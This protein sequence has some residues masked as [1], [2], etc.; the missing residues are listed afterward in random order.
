MRKCMLNFSIRIMKLCTKK[1]ASSFVWKF[2][3]DFFSRGEHCKGS[4]GQKIDS[5]KESLL[6]IFYIKANS[7][8]AK[9]VF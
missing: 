1:G 3:G 2:I 8:S 4:P 6:K 7:F 5:K 9:F